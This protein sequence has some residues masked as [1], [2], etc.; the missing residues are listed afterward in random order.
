MGLRYRTL[1]LVS[2]GI[3]SMAEDVME[4]SPSAAK[5]IE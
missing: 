1:V 2:T 5:M 3:T 4:V